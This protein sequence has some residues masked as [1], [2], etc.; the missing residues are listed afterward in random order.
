MIV[1]TNINYHFTTPPDLM[2]SGWMECLIEFIRTGFAELWGMGSVLKCRMKLHVSRY[3]HRKVIQ[4]SRPRRHW[5]ETSSEYIVIEE[6]QH[7]YSMQVVSDIQFQCTP[8]FSGLSYRSIILVFYAVILQFDSMARYH[9][10]WVWSQLLCN[11]SSS[12]EFWIVTD[13]QQIT[14][15]NLCFRDV[16]YFAFDEFWKADGLCAVVFLNIGWLRI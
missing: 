12:E 4:C 7:L 10:L 2:N 5:T 15:G 1:R 9:E 8:R 11:F 16:W 6:R 13:L 3:G 14:F